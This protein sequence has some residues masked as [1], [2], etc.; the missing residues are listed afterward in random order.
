MLNL[1]NNPGG[2]LWR[3][4]K[5]IIPGGG[6]LLSK[7]SE[8]FLPDNWPAY[9]TR[10]VGIDLW[11]LEGQQYQDFTI[12]GVG[13]AILGYA[14]QDVNQAVKKAIDNGSMGTLNSPEEVVLAEK[15]CELH[16][17][18]EMA[19]F[20]RSGG[21]AMAVAVRIARAASGKST[22]AFCG[23]HGWSDWY[24]ATNLSGANGLNEH[25]L[26]G[27]EPVGVPPQLG[28]TILP[29]SYNNI[30]DL[31]RLVA[32]CS[33]IGVIVVETVRHQE[34]INNF[35]VEVRKIATRIGAVLIFDEITIGW[36]LNVGGAHLVYG[37]NP[38]IA[39]FAKAISNGFPM[40]AIIGRQSVMQAAQ[41]TFISSTSW[42]ERIGPTAALATIKK[43]VENN[44]PAHLYEIGRMIGNGWKQ[45][46]ANHGL[47]ITVVGPEALVTFS[48]NYGDQSQAVRTLFTQEM[49]KY[50]YLA[51]SSVYVCLAH[52]PERVEKYLS[53]VDAVF[54]FIAKA[55]AREQV[56]ALLEGPIAHSGF[57]RLN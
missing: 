23:Y 56:Q 14:D 34:P 1:K 53:A 2:D 49:L 17:W 57:K 41:K 30:A 9:Y 42:T 12:M 33:D 10:A 51:S 48:F 27:L 35:L 26:P 50:G 16:P 13:T 20:T 55:I 21:E 28:G 31:E 40:A 32:N 5:T 37:I 15:L 29:F 52:T 24:L 4:A 45:L 22:V 3:K 47:S 18:A 44:V 6:Q 36:R 7:R 8:M 43:L 39:V 25:L 54:A 46:A 38:D 11:G 19:R